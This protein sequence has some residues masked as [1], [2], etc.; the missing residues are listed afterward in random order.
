VCR[1]LRFLADGAARFDDRALPG[2]GW[3]LTL[4]P[5]KPHPLGATWDREGTNFALFTENAEGVELCLFD[6]DGRELRHML[7]ER[8]GFIWHG[9][10][11]GIGP[12]QRYGYRVHGPYVPARAQRFNPAKLMIDPYARSIEGPVRYELAR[13]FPFAAGD[14]EQVTDP[15]DDA[16][17]IPKCVV[18]DPGF[19]WEGDRQLET[20]WSETV[21]YELHVRGFS[22]RNPAVRDDLRGTYAG[23]A[24][25]E[26]V[27]YLRSL[28]V[29][30]V[31]L[32][33]V[34]HCADEEFLHEH[35]L[36][37]YWGYSSIGYLAPH[38]PHAA[39]ARAEDQVREFKGMV[40]AL[41]RGGIEVILDVVYNHTAEGNERGPLL[42]F[43]GIDDAAYYRLDPADPG[44]YVDVTGTGNSLDVSHPDVLRLVMDS[45]RYWVSD[46][47]VDGFRFDLAPAL[48][49]DPHDFDRG[50]AF[51]DLIR[52]DP[53]LAGVKL[54]AEPWDLGPGGYQLGNFPG[55]WREWNGAYRD[56]M[57]D[58]WR[59]HAG[60][61]AFATR[62]T[63]SSDLFGA[64]GRHPTAS[65][66]FVTAHDGFTLVD[67][68]SYERK[69]N[70]ANL[71]DN[72]DGG[73]DNR[74]W[75]L[76]VEGPTDDV[77]I[78]ARRDR[79]RRNF[80]TTLLLSQGVPM[81]LGGD[82]LSRTQGGNN[83]AWCQ[84]NE[85]SWLDWNL[86]DRARAHLAFTRRLIELRRSQPVFRRTNFLAD[87]K[88]DTRLPEAWWFRPDG[89]KLAQADWQSE[90]RAL[91]VFLNGEEIG[92]R[93]P[94]GE[95]VV[96]D[97]FVLLVN[98][99]DGA[100]T[101]TLPP[102]RFGRRWRLE[103]ATADPDI[104]AAVLPAGAT[105]EVEA[106][107]MVLLQRE[108]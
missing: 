37:N 98:A 3:E 21:I 99:G 49:R 23:L 58:F 15:G 63:G 16:A 25:E 38:A 39:A 36:T 11:P 95:P 57:R 83:N 5:G 41:H 14:D 73:D 77:E 93:S 90:A 51:F 24:S 100:I 59:G 35:G 60:L 67:L 65:I 75:N 44:R 9:Y 55:H 48:A 20:P 31:E 4:W 18:I 53:V 28:G 7:T 10:M 80:L 26:A 17:A 96:G 105:V 32:L 84:D 64:T 12:G 103:L 22:L 78:T 66:N 42:S 13:T 101:F 85:T 43:R 2:G 19:D 79:Q 45:L 86:D 56:T 87:G 107:A 70:E 108:S 89:R 68:V 102:P 50:S 62:F 52:Q 74:S 91:G 81:L 1:T 104:P 29:T 33:P 106:L 34:H 69:H 27:A 61:A 88:T 46:C 72:R 97:S 30:A 82:E 94:R 47:H 54:I 6:E 40:K 92:E 8:T 76:G 71:L